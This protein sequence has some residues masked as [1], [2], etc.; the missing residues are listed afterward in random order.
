MGGMPCFLQQP[1]EAK[2]G[3]SKT[4]RMQQRTQARGSKN[5]S[6]VLCSFIS[7][8]AV[9]VLMQSEDCQLNSKQSG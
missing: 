2:Q 8:L 5:P 6:R 4:L 7:E 1:A 9:E 3:E